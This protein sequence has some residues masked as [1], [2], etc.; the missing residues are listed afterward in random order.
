MSSYYLGERPTN[1]LPFDDLQTI[2]HFI[3][4][5]FATM[6][7]EKIG[8]ENALKNLQ[9][10]QDDRDSVYDDIMLYV[11][12]P[13]CLSMCHYCNFNKFQYPFR[14]EESLGAYVDYLIKEI[15]YYLRLPYV[16]SRSMT[17]WLQH[18]PATWPG[19]WPHVP[20]PSPAT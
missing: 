3:V 16:Q 14:E 4:P 15:D 12:V 19:H 11:H 7:W 2:Q 5:N 18:Q 9:R 10:L 8:H 17:P 13:Y 20:A 1:Y 6:T